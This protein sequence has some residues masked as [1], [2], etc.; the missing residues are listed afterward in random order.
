LAHGHASFRS[1]HRVLL[2]VAGGLLA[3]LVALGVAMAVVAHRAEPFVRARIVEAIGARFHA[4]VEL[5][6][7]HISLGNGLRGEWG[8][9]AEGRGLRI[10]P[11]AQVE[12][13]SAPSPPPPIQ[14]LIRLD[15]FR[16]H[17]PLRYEPGTPVVI[18]MVELNGLAVHV[19]PRSHFLHAAANASN[20]ADAS[21]PKPGASA[22][23]FL[24]DTIVCRRAQLVLENGNPEKLPVEID[25]AQFKLTGISTHGAMH[26]DASLTNP[27]PR[28][29]IHTTGD[30][31]PWQVED[32][33]ESAVAG[34]YRFDNADLAD[35]KGIAGILN[36]TGH[37]R[38]TLRDLAVDGET[39]T[40]DFR[41]SHFDNA[42]ALHTQFHAR[43]DGT[44]GDTWLDD[45]DA[46]LGRSH[47]DVQGKIVRVLA[48]EA[49]GPPHSIGH[50]IALTVNVD[51][52]RIEDFVHL[53]SHG[54]TPLLTGNLKLKTTLHIPPGP[55]PVHER[56]KLNGQFLLDDAKFAS[57]KVQDRIKS[58]S[59]RGQGRPGEVK[60]TDS[61]SMRSQMQGDFQLA[62]GIVTLPSLTYTVPGA[63]I[64]L[65]GTYGLEGGAL[66][67]TG[68]AKTDATVSQMVGGWKGLLL[69]PADRFFKKDGA[70]AEV[71]V[72]IGGTREK[73]E[74]GV[75]LKSMKSTTPQRPGENQ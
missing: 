71:P 31:G 33:G 63:V 73:P 48:A 55:A 44:D 42:L 11:P 35:F 34:E 10:W 40:P 58:L 6:S 22:V 57:E 36:S 52:G 49:G 66:A 24:V 39:D 4:R 75:D 72:H 64:Q 37:Y 25:F 50:D 5:D 47:L 62:A 26:Y 43:V 38:G 1:R 59:L 29:A 61:A 13:V 2:W 3:V 18:S 19:P 20:V 69:K 32:P 14:P 28:G 17:A 7:F 67:F 60:T 45:V 68:T 27:R 41:L 30:F 70:G 23:R 21:Q 65:K 9:W 15:E 53:A 12:G 46:T 16:F 56:M 8:L 51:R 54:S 74:F